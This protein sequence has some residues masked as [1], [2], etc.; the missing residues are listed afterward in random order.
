MRSLLTGAVVVAALLA[1]VPAFA[2]SGMSTWGAGSYGW[3][4]SHPGLANTVFPA[5]VG[6]VYGDAN[7]GP[8]DFWMGP[9]EPEAAP[10]VTKY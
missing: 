6:F 4:E 8:W 10:L 5:D 1:S 7:R 9:S 3:Y 2:Q